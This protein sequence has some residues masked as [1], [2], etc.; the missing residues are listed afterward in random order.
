[1]QLF[2][3]AELHAQK[4]THLVS[5]DES[6]HILRVLRKK[7]GDQIFLTNGL[8]DGFKAEI[9]DIKSKRCEVKILEHIYESPLPYQLH[10]AIAP[11][12]SSDRFEFF[13]EK[14]TE[15]GVTEITPLL[16]ENSERKRLNIDRCVK[17]I[18][19]AMKQSQRF[20]LP[21]LNTMQHYNLWLKQDF[22]EKHKCIAHCEENEKV[23]FKDTLQAQKSILILIGP[24][25][26]FTPEEIKQALA[27]DF[28]P[29]SLGEK[30]LRTETAGLVTCQ[31]VSTCKFGIHRK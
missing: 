12:K 19:N 6:R 8:G 11:T 14:A 10:L 7:V 27:H 25:G 16:C 22:K 15:I 21:Q 2:Y 3:D 29:V 5:D 30:R 17:I 20:H 1:M 4:E 9:K 28:L 18:S 24:E 23:D 13:L 31:I 26:D